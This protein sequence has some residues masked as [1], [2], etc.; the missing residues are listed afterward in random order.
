A[1]HLDL[2]PLG[3]VSGADSQLQVALFGGAAGYQVYAPCGSVGLGPSGAGWVSFQGCESMVDLLVVAVDDL[4]M[5]L[6]AFYAAG[7]T[8]GPAANDAGGYPVDLTSATYAGL[9][10]TTFHYSGV[11]A[12]IAAVNTTQ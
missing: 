6:D 5:P 10:P 8:I 12:T 3:P 7:V 1:L 9:A 4:S 11:P 2:A